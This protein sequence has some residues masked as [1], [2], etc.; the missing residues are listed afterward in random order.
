MLVVGV[1]LVAHRGHLAQEKELVHELVVRR[2]LRLSILFGALLAFLLGRDVR[3][4]DDVGNLL[5][6]RVNKIFHNVQQLILLAI[7]GLGTRLNGIKDL[8]HVLRDVLGERVGGEGFGLL[9][10]FSWLKGMKKNLE[11]QMK[12]VLFCSGSC[13]PQGQL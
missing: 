12:S 6:L 8:E 11:I 13:F 2:L 10:A 1:D 5:R 3:G 4:E 7:R 9:K